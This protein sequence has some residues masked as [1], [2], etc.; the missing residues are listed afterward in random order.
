MRLGDRL[1]AL[2]VPLG[3][4]LG[5][6]REQQLLVLD[7]LLV[8]ELL[9][10]AQTRRHVVEGAAE[11]AELV[12]RTLGHLHVEVALGDAVHGPDESVHGSR[13][14][15]CEQQR[16]QR[17]AEQDA[18]Q[19]QQQRAG[20]ITDRG[21]GFVLVHVRHDDPVE[22]VDLEGCIR[23]EALRVRVLGGDRR[24]GAA[25]ERLGDRLAVHRLQLHGAVDLQDPGRDPRCGAV[26]DDD[27][28]VPLGVLSEKP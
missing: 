27:F 15:L 18:E 25:L 1:V 14:H 6:E 20:E 21:E 9:L 13:E 28:L 12:A 8:D 16:Q 10:D 11:V 4:T 24:A 5:H 23:D 22:S 26:L 2:L 3:D 7:L 17:D 19:R